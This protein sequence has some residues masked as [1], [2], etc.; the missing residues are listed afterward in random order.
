MEKGASKLDITAA[1]EAFQKTL[2]A[3]DEGIMKIMKSNLTAEMTQADFER[4]NY[5]VGINEQ[6]RTAQRHFNKEKKAAADRLAI[7]YGAYKGSNSAGFDDETGRIRNYIQEMSTAKCEQDMEL[8]GL[9]EWLEPLEEANERC[10]K[11]ADE[12]N[13]EQRDKDAAGNV[14]KLRLDN[15]N[16]YRKVVEQINALALIKG[17]SLYADL[18]T[19][20]NTRIDH[21]RVSVSLRIGAGK[22]GSTGK[23]DQKPNPKPENPGGLDRPDEI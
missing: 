20:W 4:D 3:E 23:G 22:G 7:V 8:L 9:T 17:D 2:Q 11:L 18:I 6:I 14:K 21:Y 19:R 1:F 16:A 12:R 10:A 15:D 13:T 5:F